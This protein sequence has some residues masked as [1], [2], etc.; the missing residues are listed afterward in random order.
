MIYG[1]AYYP[2]HWPYERM[3]VDAKLMQKAK[4]NVVR[5][6]EFAWSKIERIEG[7]W[8]FDWLDDAISLFASYGINTVLC[9][10]TA[11]PPK[12]LMNKHPDIYGVDIKGRQLKFGGRRHY[13]FT[14]PIYRKYI[15]I[16]VEKM[17]IRYGNNRNVIAWQVDNEL[18]GDHNAR[19]FCDN[20]KVGFRQYLRAKFNDIEELNTAWGTIVWSQGY[21]CFD[22]VELPDITHALPNPSLNVEYYRFVSDTIINYQNY[23]VD[24]LREYTKNQAITT[25]L[26]GM[27]TEMDHHKLTKSLDFISSDFYPNLTVERPA[28]HKQAMSIDLSICEKTKPMWRMEHQCGMP[29]GNIMFAPPKKGD[30]ARWVYQSVAHGCDG[31]LF[32]RWRTNLVGAEQHWHGILGHDGVPRRLYNEAKQLGEELEKLSLFLENTKQKA[33]VAIVHDYEVDWVFE[34]QPHII[35]FNHMEHLEKYYK[36]FFDL[37]VPVEFI[38]P[39]ADFSKYELVV[40]PNHSIVEDDRAKK[41]ED[42]VNSGGNVLF[43]F[44]SGIR[45]SNNT[46]YPLTPPGKLASL[47]G[48]QIIDYGVIGDYENVKIELSKEKK[49]NCT[50]WYEEIELTTANSIARYTG[51][52]GNKSPALTC[53]D[54]GDGRAWYLGT[55]PEEEMLKTILDKICVI[56]SIDKNRFSNN[57]DI[58]VVCRENEDRKILFIINHSDEVKEVNLGENIMIDILEDTALHGTCQL[59]PKQVKVIKLDQS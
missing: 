9:T 33:K 52:C 48:I 18:G 32:F 29:G 40:L 3:I 51:D 39:S 30:L 38:P 22:E 45:N 2:E 50:W 56:S 19:C 17:A 11:T 13:C 57:I 16:I 41:F 20:C 55:I 26:F 44:R 10:P 36:A 12:W 7:V 27:F 59:N 31:I 43:D 49:G 15:N 34:V 37:G 5:M 53:N 21:T 47:L 6:A 14:S 24:I 28:P 35:G 46:I 4:M 25:N 8:D 1:A 54:F 58:E 42:Y 23:Q